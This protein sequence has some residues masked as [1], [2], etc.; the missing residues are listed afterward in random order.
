[1][2]DDARERP[3][4]RPKPF[5]FPRRVAAWAAM[6]GGAIATYRGA[7]GELG[8]IFLI[9]GPALMVLGVIGFFLYRWMARR[10]L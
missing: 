3:P 1:M 7:T 8:S 10:G 9:V 4:G 2:S 6:I 5:D